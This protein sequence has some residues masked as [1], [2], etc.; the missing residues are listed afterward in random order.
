MLEGKYTLVP[1]LK[2]VEVSYGGF[3]Y[4]I[5]F[6]FEE[7]LP[8]QELIMTGV[9]YDENKTSESKYFKLENDR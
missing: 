2:E 8:F 4:P 5:V 7:A 1:S 9:I 6:N 3:G